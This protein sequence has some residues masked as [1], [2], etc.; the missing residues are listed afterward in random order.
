MNWIIDQMVF[1]E[2]LWKFNLKTWTVLYLFIEDET[3][4]TEYFQFQ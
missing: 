3:E 4:F 1:R 2:D